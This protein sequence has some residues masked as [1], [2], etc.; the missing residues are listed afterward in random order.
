MDH[1]GTVVTP[2]D[3]KSVDQAI[4]ALCA[5]GVETIAV[6]LLHAYANPAHEQAIQARIQE[7][8]PDISVSLSSD[9]SPKFREYER[10]N[11]VVANAYV[12]PIVE[13]YMVR[14]EGA[15]IQHGLK[16]EFFVMQSSGGLV[17][18]AIAKAY[19]IR[20]IESGPAA[21]VLMGGIVGRSEGRDHVI[22][23]DMGGTTAKLGA[24]DGRAMAEMNAGFHQLAHGERGDCHGRV[25]LRLCRRGMWSAP[26]RRRPDRT[27]ERCP[28]AFNPGTAFPREVSMAGRYPAC[29][30]K[31]S[32]FSVSR[33]A[34]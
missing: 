10:T 31:S 30:S 12:K 26:A 33:R 9:V 24:V 3:L 19:P 7:R 14:L 6:S 34:P 23:F 27:P 21:G 11:T 18:P 20:I 32:S 29:S 1:V 15:L 2:L 16:R 8:A 25:I 22:T 5:A 17:T 4:D 28:G 13:H